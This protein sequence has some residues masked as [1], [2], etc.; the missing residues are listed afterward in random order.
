AIGL[1]P[2]APAD[3]RGIDPV[4]LVHLGDAHERGAP[5]QRLGHGGAVDRLPF[6]FPGPAP[7]VGLDPEAARRTIPPVLCV[8]ADAVAGRLT[9]AVE[10]V[11]HVERILQTEPRETPP[12]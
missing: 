10:K 11:G 12:L 4:A 8:E 5:A 6:R 7:V 2:E 3:G 9:G 1:D